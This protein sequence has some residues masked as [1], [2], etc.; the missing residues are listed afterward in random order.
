M[1]LPRRRGRLRRDSV[2]LV[3]GGAG[4]IGAAIATNLHRRGASVMLVDIPGSDVDGVAARLGPDR[5]LVAHADVTDRAQLDAAVER[6]L[7]RFGRLDV[8][9]ANAGIASGREASTIASVA[10]G[11]FE[12]VIGVNLQ[13]VWNTVRAALPHI[14]D[15]GG[16]VLLTSSTYAYLN[17]LANAPYAAS[18][19]AVE[20]IGRALRVELAGTEATAGVL[21]PG[22]VATPIADVAFGSDSIATALV[23]K[24]FPSFLLTPLTPETFAKAAVRGIE[25]RSARIQVPRR[26]VPVSLLR[27]IVNPVTDRLL[28]RNGEIVRLTGELER[29]SPTS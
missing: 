22:W 4:G 11:V 29:R 13:G 14:V 25:K 2:V 23:S 9:I 21:Y 7:S 12:R 3:T 10:D 16:Y 28:E 15:S 8:V 18:K 20:Q 19:A 26:W 1:N 17:G 24:A 6:T 27:G 5:V